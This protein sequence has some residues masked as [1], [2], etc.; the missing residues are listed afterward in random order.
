VFISRACLAQLLHFTCKIRAFLLNKIN[1]LKFTTSLFHLEVT[2][3]QSL[4]P[5]LVAES[6]ETQ[7]LSPSFRT[8]RSLH[9]NHATWCLPQDQERRWYALGTMR[10]RS[11]CPFKL[12]HHTCLTTCCTSLVLSLHQVTTVESVR[13][14]TPLFFLI[15]G[16]MP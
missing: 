4:S 1:L 14:S 7:T 13:S 6:I 16:L 10:I 5:H 8:R 11:L 2:S 12:G 3:L 9:G 15:L